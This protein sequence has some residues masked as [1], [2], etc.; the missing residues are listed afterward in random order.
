MG[1]ASQQAA[2]AGGSSRDVSAQ[3]IL[4]MPCVPGTRLTSTLWPHPDP[5]SCSPAETDTGSSFR[6]GLSSQCWEVTGR[7]APPRG[8]PSSLYW[9]SEDTPPSSTGWPRGIGRKR[10]DPTTPDSSQPAGVGGAG[11][12]AGLPS[13]ASKLSSV[14]GPDHP[15]PRYS[16]RRQQEPY[17]TPGSCAGSFFLCPESQGGRKQTLSPLPVLGQPLLWLCMWGASRV[18]S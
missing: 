12:A 4:G 8:Q 9:P 7:T 1:P 13:S 3:V 16:R 10:G 18:G 6:R 5:S 17:G 14:L 15:V 11:D 2:L